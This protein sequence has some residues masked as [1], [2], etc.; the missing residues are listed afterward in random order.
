MK[1]FTSLEEMQK[2]DGPIALAIGMFDGL[3][4]GHQHI[5]KS[6]RQRVGNSGNVVILTF[7][8]HPEEIL[9]NKKINLIYDSHSKLRLL[10]KE[11][12][13][14]TLLLKFTSEMAKM[15]Y[16]SFLSMLKEKIDFSYLFFG[17]VS[18]LGKE[19][20]GTQ[21][22]IINLSHKLQF[23]V[24]Y[25]PF[26]EV[27]GNIVSS[28]CIRQAI[29]NK[30]FITANTLLGYPFTLFFQA[31]KSSEFIKTPHVNIL[32]MCMQNI[33]VPE[34]KYSVWVETEASE[35][36]SAL[37]SVKKNKLSLFYMKSFKLED[38]TMSF[39]TIDNKD[40]FLCPTSPVVL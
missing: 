38:F 23:E 32:S 37:L 7:A 34:G 16:D 26:V 39:D 27:N 22:N 24:I 6:M 18:S 31:S 25:L 15:E 17:E 40:V 8:N 28:T 13:D 5:I 2:S 29:N 33:I 12:V 10:E 35:K 1:I 21:E 4:L 36:F 11:N 30:D 19:K 14:V 20:K 3:H 9:N